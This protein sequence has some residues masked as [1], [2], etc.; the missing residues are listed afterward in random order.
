MLMS[1]LLSWAVL[2]I[3]TNASKEIEKPGPTPSTRRTATGRATASI[4]LDGRANISALTRLPP[5]PRRLGLLRTPATILAPPTHHPSLDHPF[6][7]PGRPP[8]SPVYAPWSSARPPKTSLGLLPHPGR[9][10]RPRLPNRRLHRLDHPSP[11]RHRPLISTYGL[12]LDEF[13]RAPAHAIL[14]CDLFHP[15]TIA[16]RRLYAFLVVSPPG[17]STSSASPPTRPA[18]GSRSRPATCSWTTRTPANASDSSIDAVPTPT[19]HACSRLFARPVRGGS[20]RRV[21]SMIA[22]RDVT[23]TGQSV[24]PFRSTHRNR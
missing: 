6:R 20:M 5:A 13:L 24:R 12:D 11:R 1:K 22:S 9:A 19:V 18:R 2:R 8:S 16:L 15:D 3:P 7:R 4:Q 14:I 21:D 10:R 23:P 17:G